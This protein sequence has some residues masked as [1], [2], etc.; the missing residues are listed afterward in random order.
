[1][2]EL[3]NTNMDIRYVNE[4]DRPEVIPDERIRFA[5]EHQPELVIWN[6]PRPLAGLE[7]WTG[8]F[9]CGT[10][11]AAGERGGALER[12]AE[13]LDARQIV[14]V[15]NADVDAMIDARL[16]AAGYS[17]GD[18]A[19]VGMG[20]AEIAADY[21]LPWAAASPTNRPAGR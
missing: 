15:T 2:R 5:L 10:F 11:Y 13:R 7:H 3:R 19:E 4:A 21:G 6:A 12:D 9:V 14:F 20:S 8:K 1:M 18:Y 16:A 17:R